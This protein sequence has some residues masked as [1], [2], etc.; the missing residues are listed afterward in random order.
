M[1][2]VCFF[3]IPRGIYSPVENKVIRSSTHGSGAAT[4]FYAYVGFDSIATSGEEARDPGRSIPLATLFSMA[5]VTVGYMLVSGA[6]TLVVPYWEIN[7]TAALPEA[8]SSRGIPWAKYVIRRA[9]LFICDSI[10]FVTQTLLSR[11][12][13][14]IKMC[15]KIL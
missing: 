1:F 9:I 10:K 8:F 5:I 11:F 3:V 6:L 12:L 4:C 14:V 15:K 2:F 13:F 7:P